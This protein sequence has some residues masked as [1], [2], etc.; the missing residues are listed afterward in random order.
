[1]YSDAQQACDQEEYSRDG[2]I[3]L[4]LQKKGGSHL[5]EWYHGTIHNAALLLLGDILNHAELFSEKPSMMYILCPQNWLAHVSSVL[6]QLIIVRIDEETAE[7]SD[8]I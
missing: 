3:P 2:Q 8:G 6:R 7:L 1:M 4:Q 5:S